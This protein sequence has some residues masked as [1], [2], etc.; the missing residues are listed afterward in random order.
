[1]AVGGAHS[2]P[3]CSHPDRGLTGEGKDMVPETPPCENHVWTGTHLCSGSDQLITTQL[4]S[5][6][7][8]RS[9]CCL[10]TGRGGRRV[11]MCGF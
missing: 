11:E 7:I 1:M 2:V 4:I 10:G 8:V 6:Q 9:L 5:V 3:S